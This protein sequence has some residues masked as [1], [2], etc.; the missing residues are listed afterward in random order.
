MK[1]AVPTD[2]GKRIAE[3]FGRASS[4]LVF[5]VNE[6]EIVS[7]ELIDSKTPHVGGQHAQHA[8]GWFM[9]ALE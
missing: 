8:G 3:H 6:K 9:D 4:F 2:D 7:K 5:E 1:V